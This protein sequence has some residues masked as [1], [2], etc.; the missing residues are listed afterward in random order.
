MRPR[1]THLT[2]AVAAAASIAIAPAVVASADTQHRAPAAATV[3]ARGREFSFRLSRTSA[4]KPGKVTFTFRNV[5]TVRHDFKIGG[6]QTPLIGPGKTA[7]LA[8][9]FHEKGRF[10]F[11]C[12]VPGHA[13]AGMRGVF[14]VR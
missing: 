4:A 7:A 11:I 3:A 9:T 6:K 10:P 2:I 5:G 12:T 14:T 1:A 13:A 8:V